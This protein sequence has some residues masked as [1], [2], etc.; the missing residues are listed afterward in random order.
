MKHFGSRVRL[1]ASARL[2]G[3]ADSKINPQTS[4]AAARELLRAL[5][6]RS[7]R[8]FTSY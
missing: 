4:L 1:L 7:Q 2:R 5:A 3:S 6:G 8:S